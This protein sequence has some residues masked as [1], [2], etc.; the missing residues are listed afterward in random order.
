MKTVIN[1]FINGVDYSKPSE[2]R[3]CYLELE[4]TGGIKI[5]VSREFK[6]QYDNIIA[7]EEEYHNYLTK[8]AIPGK[9]G[10]LIMCR[11]K[12][13]ECPFTTFD[14]D[15]PGKRQE[16]SLDKLTNEEGFDAASNEDIVAD[17]VLK[18]R[19]EKMWSEIFKLNE[20]EQ[21]ILSMWS[22]GMSVRDIAK[23]VNKGKSVVNDKINKII[24]ILQEKCR[25]F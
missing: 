4:H 10:R 5:Y 24:A 14:N 16:A 8:C 23:K 18:E 12:C 21:A 2:D 11:H 3:P 20:E 15:Q 17:Y 1:L 7:D 6:R 13:E 19:K 22:K 9:N 25:G